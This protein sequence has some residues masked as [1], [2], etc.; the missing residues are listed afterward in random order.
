MKNIWKEFKKSRLAQY[1]LYGILII[2]F[3]HIFGFEFTILISLAFIIG[4]LHY[5]ENK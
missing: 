2:T 5:Q 4:E 3:K 1:L